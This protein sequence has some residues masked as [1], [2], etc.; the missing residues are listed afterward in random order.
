M[1]LFLSVRE[2][3]LTLFMLGILTDNHDF[4]L[5]LYDF[6]LLANLFNRRSDFHFITS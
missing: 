1:H 6:A 3:T 5:A 2:L 4:T